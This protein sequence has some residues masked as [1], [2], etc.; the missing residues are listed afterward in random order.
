[1]DTFIRQLE[2][3]DHYASDPLLS[4]DRWAY[5]TESWEAYDGWL[6]MDGFTWHNPAFSW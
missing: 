4:E 3:E 5:V 2:A 6:S 1:M